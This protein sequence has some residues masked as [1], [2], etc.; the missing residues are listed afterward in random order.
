[1]RIS[2]GLMNMMISV[3]CFWP[4]LVPAPRGMAHA[5]AVPAAVSV[6][7]LARRRPQALLTV[8]L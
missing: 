7:R 3:R 5:D 6:I 2:R 8:S 4:D 1:L